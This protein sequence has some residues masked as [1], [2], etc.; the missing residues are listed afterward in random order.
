MLKKF[1]VKLV[2]WREKETNFALRTF[3]EKSA[4]ESRNAQERHQ[5]IMEGRDKKYVSEMITPDVLGPSD[6][7]SKEE[8]QE[9]S[10]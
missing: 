4:Q 3:K 10:E 5:Q 2:G 7:V 6:Q 9:I 1:L 8:K